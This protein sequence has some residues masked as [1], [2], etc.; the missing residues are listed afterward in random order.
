MST[1]TIKMSSSNH[2]CHLK[3]FI[4]FPR[5]YEIM[6]NEIRVINI[7]W[8]WVNNFSLLFFTAI[9][10][11]LNGSWHTAVVIVQ[12]LSCVQLF[13]ISWTA[14][15]QAFLSFTVSW[16]L[17]KCMSIESVM[18]SNHLSLCCPILLLPS[19]WLWKA[20]ESFPMSWFFD[21]G[22]QSIGASASASVLPM[23]IHGWFPLGLTGVILQFRGLSRVFSNT[24]VQKHQFLGAQPSSWSNSHIHSWL[25]ERPELWQ[26][27][28]LS[29][30]WCL[31]FLIHCLGLS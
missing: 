20:T 24:M 16:S 5:L 3:I 27:G 12:S 10:K 9:S 22:G 26:C 18:L 25:L 7:S 1:S 21:S 8:K 19:T 6:S 31:G 14:A 2:L 29:E 17:L 11:Y 30:K 4:H 13:A 23:N 28:S 15:C